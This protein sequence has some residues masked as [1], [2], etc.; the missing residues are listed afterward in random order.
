MSDNRLKDFTVFYAW[1]SDSPNKTNRTFIEAAAKQALK[2]ISLPPELYFAPRLEQDTKGVPGTPDIANTILRKIESSDVF[3]ADVTLI[4]TDMKDMEKDM[5]RPTP[6]PNVLL[7]LGYALA[8]RGSERV[9][10][11]M[12]E[13]FGSFEKLP[14]DLRHKKRP[15]WYNLSPDASTEEKRIAKEQLSKNIQEAISLIAESNSSHAGPSGSFV[16]SAWAEEVTSGFHERLRSGNIEGMDVSEGVLALAVIPGRKS[17]K[18]VDL[19]SLETELWKRLR[20]IAAGGC[21]PRR[22]SRYFGTVSQDSFSSVVID[23][24]EFT[25]EEVLLAANRKIVREDSFTDKLRDRFGEGVWAI[26]PAKIERVTIKALAGYLPLMYDLQV[27]MPWLVRISL[28][29]LGPT[30]AWSAD[31]RV[32]SSGDRVFRETNIIADFIEVRSEEEFANENQV[33]CLLRPAFNYMWRSFGFK[34][35]PY[36]NRDGNWIK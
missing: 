31:L 26:Y 10:L 33:A 3:L 16:D 4:N 22:G 32:H 27:E 15:I 7:E 23:V 34:A 8:S 13:Y 2:K 6:N 19:A 14:F 9:I 24:T 25:D 35:S 12:N 21:N 30:V 28:L 36:Y 29:E 17:S 1:Q 5:L 20:P 11:V 18:R